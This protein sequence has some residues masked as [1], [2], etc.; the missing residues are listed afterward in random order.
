MVLLK[1]L[2]RPII[3]EDLLTHRSGFTYDFLMGCHV[4]PLYSERDISD[5][6]NKSIEDKCEY[7]YLNY[8]WPI[9]QVLDLIILYLL[10][11]WLGLL[12]L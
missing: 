1:S 3:V 11:C 7:P 8:L 12:K 4:A 5:D 6:G 10:M 2:N 9:S